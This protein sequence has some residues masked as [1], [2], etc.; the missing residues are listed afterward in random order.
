M[1]LSVYISTSMRRGDPM[2]KIHL[3]NDNNCVISCS[4]MWM[5]GIFDNKEN[6]D[7]AFE[8]SEEQIIRLQQEKNKTTCLITM[9]DLLS[10]KK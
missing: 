10:I 6:A 1:L 3:L 8:F 4:G 7:K 2:K 5:P 9:N